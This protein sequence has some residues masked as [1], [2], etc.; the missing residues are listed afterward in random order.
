MNKTNRNRVKRKIN[1]KRRKEEKGETDRQTNR[2][3][4]TQRVTKI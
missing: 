2:H 1:I 4:D 3:T